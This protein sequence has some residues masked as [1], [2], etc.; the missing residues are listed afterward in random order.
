MISSH[1]QKQQLH[2]FSTILNFETKQTKN[3]MA[4][5]SGDQT[6]EDHRQADL[7]PYNS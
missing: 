2:L 5:R 7:A 3:S 4:S 6:G 1:I